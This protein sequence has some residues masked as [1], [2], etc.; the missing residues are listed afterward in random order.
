MEKVLDRIQRVNL[1]SPRDRSIV[2]FKAVVLCLG[3]IK[4]L[5]FFDHTIA[6]ELSSNLAFYKAEYYLHIG[7][8]KSQ[9]LGNLT[10]LPE[11]NVA[12]QDNRD[13]ERVRLLRGE[14]ES[15]LYSATMSGDLTGLKQ[16]LTWEVNRYQ[17]F[18]DCFGEEPYASA[19]IILASKINRMK[20]VM[21]DRSEPFSPPPPAWQTEWVRG[22]SAD[23]VLVGLPM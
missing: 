14:A 6:Y 10:M 22:Q 2:T 11:S 12:V 8:M 18:S 21:L 16:W 5:N 20:T 15:A 19:S 13:F 3:E 23:V 7:D 4:G 17:E 1:E 9:R